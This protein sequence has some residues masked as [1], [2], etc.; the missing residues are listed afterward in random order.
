M[1]KV[2][3]EKHGDFENSVRRVFMEVSIAEK[4]EI[5]H[6]LQY[7]D[8]LKALVTMSGRPPPTVF[9][10]WRGRACSPGMFARPVRLCVLL[11]GQ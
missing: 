5:P 1:I 4:L 3:Y 7:S 11:Q 2:D 10:V 6:M 9:A 8:G